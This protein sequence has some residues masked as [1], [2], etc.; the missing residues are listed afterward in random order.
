MKITDSQIKKLSLKIYK[1]LEENHMI[2]LLSSSEAI[3]NRIAGIIAQDAKLEDDIEKEARALL[4]KFR[5]QIEAGQIDS[6]EMFTRIKNQ[7][8]KDKKFIK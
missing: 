5:P 8:I 2:E 4:D 7:L 1:K 6:H 3:I